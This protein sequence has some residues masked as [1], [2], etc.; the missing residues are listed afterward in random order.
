MWCISGVCMVRVCVVPFDVVYV[1]SVGGKCM[2]CVVC[3]VCMLCMF[4]VLFSGISVVSF[5]YICGVCCYVTCVYEVCACN[6]CGMH[7]VHYIV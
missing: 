3:C 1:G 6:L 7:G 2:V 5:W 4:G